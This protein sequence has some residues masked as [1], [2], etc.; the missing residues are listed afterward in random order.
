MSSKLEFTLLR[1]WHAA[2]AGGF[3]MAYVT[4]DAIPKAEDLHDGLT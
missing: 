4:A 1:L 3:V 2:L